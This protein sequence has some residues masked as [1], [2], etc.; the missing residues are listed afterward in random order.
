MEENTCEKQ[1]IEE[2]IYPGTIG[3]LIGVI[4]LGVYA[5]DTLAERLIYSIVP[6][7]IFLAIST[8]I[9]VGRLRS[10]AFL[11]TWGLRVSAQDFSIGRM[12]CIVSSRFP[13]WLCRVSI[14]PWIMK[15]PPRQ[16]WQT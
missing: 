11:V 3:F 8:V 2:A 9:T 12:F 1:A 16:S 10:R 6:A 15:H 7:S 14:L 4:V 5:G 13:R